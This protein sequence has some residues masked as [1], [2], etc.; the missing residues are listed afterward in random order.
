V[1]ESRFFPP[2]EIEGVRDLMHKAGYP[3][4]DI[5]GILGENWKRISGAVWS[6]RVS[7]DGN[8]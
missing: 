4:K 2:E 1:R 8:C 6:K 5:A 7:P 3:Q